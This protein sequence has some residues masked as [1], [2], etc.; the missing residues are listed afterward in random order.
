MKDDPNSDNALSYATEQY[1]DTGCVTKGRYKRFNGILFQNNLLL[2]GDQIVVPNSFRFNITDITHRN[3][4]HSGIEGTCELIS[5][6]FMW[7]GMRD[8]VT[9]FC[10]HCHA[11]AAN[12]PIRAPKAPLVE[13]ADLPVRLREQMI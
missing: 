8:F 4:G 5:G 13:F 3:G 7:R 12:K 9:D 10:N 6:R 1:N 11:C 2:R